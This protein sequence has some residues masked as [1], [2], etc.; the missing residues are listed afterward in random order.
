MVSEAGLFLVVPVTAVWQAA[1]GLGWTDLV[2]GRGGVVVAAA[3]VGAGVGGAAW[4]RSHRWR[5][6]VVAAVLSAGYA[7]SGSALVILVGA[8]VIELIAG[9]P[10]QRLERTRVPVGTVQRRFDARGPSGGG[11]E[12]WPVPSPAAEGDSD[13]GAC[14]ATPERSGEDA[15]GAANSATGRTRR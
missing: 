4:W 8:L 11:I 12:R 3:L 5:G 7:S 1:T 6:V 2:L 9:W 13:G 15:A 10:R 14:D